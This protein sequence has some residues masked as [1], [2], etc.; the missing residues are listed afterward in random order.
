VTNEDGG[1][2]DDEEGTNVRGNKNHLTKSQAHLKLHQKDT[3]RSAACKLIPKSM[4]S[5]VVRNHTQ[6]Q[7]RQ[8]TIRAPARTMADLERTHFTMRFAKM[9]RKAEVAE[10][11]EEDGGYRQKKKRSN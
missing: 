5:A 6:S 3:A 11:E 10:E 1:N 7:N 9:K 8:Y 4:L 2:D